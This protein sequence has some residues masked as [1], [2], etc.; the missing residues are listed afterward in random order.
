[1][2]FSF[3]FFLSFSFVLFSN[4]WFC[5]LRFL[6]CSTHDQN[7]DSWKCLDELLSPINLISV[8]P[9][10]VIFTKNWSM[11]IQTNQKKTPRAQFLRAQSCHFCPSFPFACPQ[12]V[13]DFLLWPSPC[14]L[15]LWAHRVVMSSPLTRLQATQEQ[16]PCLIYFCSHS[17]LV[18]SKSLL[19]K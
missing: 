1:M 16:Q 11:A 5:E 7:L 13:S 19:S 3:L 6:A 14:L 15:L 18:C 8:L 12:Q 2:L 9:F 17:N 4:T 10:Y